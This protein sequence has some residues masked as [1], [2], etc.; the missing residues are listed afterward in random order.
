MA[1]TAGVHT[2]LADSMERVHRSPTEWM[3]FLSFHARFYRYN[4]SNAALIYAQRPEATACATM[5]FWNKRLNR[6]IRRGSH[7]IRLLQADGESIRYVF[8]V[9]DTTG[10]PG[11]LPKIWSAAERELPV[12]LDYIAAPEGTTMQERIILLTQEVT[13]QL[14]PEM[15]D[16]VQF[17][18]QDSLL[19]DLDDLN[20]KVLCR[21]LISRS[22]AYMTMERLGISPR[23]MLIDEDFRGVVDFSTPALQSILDAHVRSISKQILDSVE[24][25]VK[26]RS[27]ILAEQEEFSEDLSK[28]G[29]KSPLQQPTFTQRYGQEEEIK[30]EAEHDRQ[31]RN[32]AQKLS[33]GEPSRDVRADDPTGHAEESP[34]G[35]RRT[36][37]KHGA[38][39]DQET[40]GGDSRTGEIE[41]AGMGGAHEQFEARGGRSGSPGADL[42]IIEGGQGTAEESNQTVNGEPSRSGSFSMP[43]VSQISMFSMPQTTPE[44]GR[45]Q[46]GRQAISQ[47][48]IDLVLRSGSNGPQSAMRICAQ[49]HWDKPV[50]EN[51]DFLRREFGEDGKGY[52]LDGRQ[53]SAWFSEEGIRLAH[54]NSAQIQGAVLLSWEDAAVRIRAL[55]DAGEY[56]SQPELDYSFHQ[57]RI[58]LGQ[59]IWHACRDD[60]GGF[61]KEWG[62]DGGYPGESG[63]IADMLAEPEERGRI[64][65]HLE[66]AA[67]QFEKQEPTRRRWHNHQLLLRNVRDLDREP[68]QFH[69]DVMEFSFP[70]RFITRDEIDSVLRRK[71]YSDSGRRIQEYFQSNHT[72]QEKERFIREHYGIGGVGSQALDVWYDAK[73]LR[74]RRGPI[75]N[76]DAE[77]TLKWKQVASR[78]QTLINE[79]RYLKEEE[80]PQ[81]PAERIYALTFIEN[82]DHVSAWDSIEDEEVARIHADGTIQYF[83]PDPPVEIIDQIDAEAQVFWQRI[84][85]ASELEPL[86]AEPAADISHTEEK[87]NLHSVVIDLRPREPEPEPDFTPAGNYHIHDDHLGEGGTRTKADRNIEAIRTLKQIETEKRSATVGEQ[88][89]LAQYVG[90]GGIPQIFD[91]NNAD[92]KER[93]ETLRGLLTEDEFNSARASTLNAHYTSPVVIRTIYQAL[94]NMGFEAGNVLEPACGV[95]NFFGMLP[96]SMENS[97]LYGV[98]LDG[99]TGRLA[100]QLYPR[101]MLSVQGF[102]TTNYPDNFFDVAVGNVPF[103]AYRLQDRRYDKHKLLIHDYFFYKTL[104]Q[105]RPGGII[106]FVTSKGT[107][108]KKDETVRRHL[109]EK[110]DLLG[111]IRLPNTAFQKNAGTEVTTDII[112]LQ[113]RDEP[114]LNVP[115]WVHV[116]ET[117]DGVPVNQYYLDHPE[118]MLGTMRFDRSMYGNEKETTCEPLAGKELSE[119]LAEAVK[120]VR[121]SYPSVEIGKLAAEEDALPA[122]PAVQDYSYAL[123]NDRLYFRENSVMRPVTVNATAQERIRGM[124]ELRDVTRELLNAQLENRPDA[125]IADLQK[126]LNEKYDAFVE[127]YGRITSRA[128]TMAFEDDDSYYLLSSLEEL[129]EEHNFSHKA[130]IFS[131][132]TIQPAR[133]PE[134]VDTAQEALIL[135]LSERGRIDFDY[136]TELTGKDADQLIEDLQGFMFQDPQGNPSPYESWQTADEYLSG[137]VREKLEIARAAVDVISEKYT[138]NVQALE[139]VLP[140]DLEPH[141]IDV[142]LG[143]AWLPPSDVDSF[144]YELLGTN[145]YLKNSIHALYCPQTSGWNITGKS[146]D[147]GNVRARSQYGTSRANAYKILEECLNL[148]DIRIFDTVEDGD[149]RERRVLNQKETILA[150]Q[151]QTLI[152]EAFRDWIWKDPNRT[153]RLCRMYNDRFNNLRLREYDGSHLNFAGLNPEIQLRPH[154]KNAV[155]RMLY[156]G[157][158]LLAHVV[159]AGKTATMVAGIMEKKRLGLAR[160]ALVAVPNHLTQQTAAE[161]LR[162]Y[163]AAK[164]LVATKKDFEKANR[165]RFIAKIA[166]GDYD[167]VIMG[168]SQFEKIPISRERQKAMLE[169]QIHELIEGIEEI[170]HQNGERFTVKELERTRKSLE[171]RLKDLN[172]DAG[173]DQVI[174]FEQLGVD[175]LFVDEAH[176][177]K[178]C[179]IVTKMRNVA[180]VQTTEAKKSSD[181]LMKCRYISEITGNKGVVFATG[182]PISNSMVELYN[183]QRYLQNDELKKR[184]LAHFDAWAGTFGETVTAIELAPEGTGYRSKTRFSRF[185]NLPELVGMFRLIADIQTADMLNLPVPA[186]KGGKVQNICT[187]PSEF[188]KH[189][190]ETLGER[191]ETIRQGNVDPREDNML[192]VTNDGRMLALDARLIDPDQPDDPDSKINVCIRKVLEIYRATAEQKSAQLV[193]SDLSTPRSDGGFDVYHDIKRKLILQGVPEEEIAFIHD[194]NSD[195]QKEALFAKVRSGNVRVLLGSTPRMGAGTNVQKKLIALHHLDVPWRPSDLQQRDGRILRQGNENPEVQVIRYVTEGTF[196]AYSYQLVENKQRTISQ[197]LTGK[198]PVR[199]MED[200]DDLAFSYA[201]LKALAAGNPLI[202]E[203][204]DLDVQVA[205]LRLLK[206]SYNSEQYRLQRQAT[207][208]IPAEISR[209]REQIAGLDM[210]LECLKNGARDSFSIEIMNRTFD[211]R[212]DAAEYLGKLAKLQK[213]GNAVRIGRICGFELY[214]QRALFT[215]ELS[216]QLQGTNRYEASLG[217]SDLGNITR[218]ENVLKELPERK[219]R[220]QKSIEQLTG[221]LEAV[222]EQLGKPFPQ[223]EELKTKSA[224]LVELNAELDVG[225]NAPGA[226]VID[227][228]DDTPGTPAQDKAPMHQRQNER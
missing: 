160:K 5:N 146:L 109:A 37:T 74:I 103:G 129:D 181:M 225:G 159:G 140:R 69:S 49:F 192:K 202:K 209:C 206:N 113:K 15:L 151:K 91:E 114:N 178:N 170:K 154:Q 29:E 185:F 201:E 174:T 137:N 11:T 130:D 152:R 161:F 51:A 136:M 86:E 176:S 179:A 28:N 4:T 10:P 55:L 131:K 101:A 76:P 13:E 102:E 163:P 162:F 108:D 47:D 156:G 64:I 106:A 34:A 164:V 186:L 200:V 115:D 61:P 180:G 213:E 203:K 35:D 173:K 207:V 78:I 1:R 132:R 97:R 67:R 123:I 210:D 70:E 214:L 227:D 46:L 139:A 138:V 71:V 36:G 104:D 183:M 50:E 157:N 92:W 68:L 208:A 224:R 40:P 153:E 105:V 193:F 16:D 155:A 73:G 17:N 87:Q 121:G 19:E 9:A 169:E 83:D 58:W 184:G 119:Q 62:L 3:Q 32:D 21:N 168:H 167:A 187:K 72:F 8:D 27:E 116:G 220:F 94:E 84:E 199:G 124:I 30:E 7:G 117:A 98:E 24:L 59:D 158:T 22:A 66:E 79:G 150:Q 127:K 53:L 31:V 189:V 166:T 111:A 118:M 48:E 12:F 149:G 228:G 60:L 223:E 194:A 2:L 80:L 177:F 33:G 188:Q 171:R 25:C 82:V 145:R 196:D 148:R 23:E 226:A 75:L 39:A 182:T 100:Q 128:N 110:A 165:K 63:R 26:H 221:Q 141:E 142:R 135:S 89:I 95:G 56:I 205:K 65:A 219:E 198:T 14:L 43:E 38:G 147:A 88:E 45:F 57:E 93:R 54:G 144:M 18:R 212:A 133:Q 41:P 122:D 126:Q 197:V 81:E 90:W 134:H 218:I 107:L 77:I 112:F 42:R 217:D 222:K 190:V 6:W 143:S 125:E 52:L 99:I 191:A 195:L 85:E 204:M 96:E 215:G 175:M 172:D 44:E 120:H 20:L 216:I 211:K